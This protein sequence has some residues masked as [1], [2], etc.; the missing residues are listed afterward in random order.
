VNGTA[1]L[2]DKAAGVIRKLQTGVAQFYAL[3]MILGIA[4][5]LLWIILSL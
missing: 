1:I 2:I 5:A 4:A 3:I